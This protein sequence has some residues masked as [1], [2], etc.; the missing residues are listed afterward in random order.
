M[1]VTNVRSIRPKS[2]NLNFKELQAYANFMSEFRDACMFCISETWFCDMIDNDSVAID[3]FGVPFRTDRNF[4][5]S[6]KQ[7]GGGV[8][9]YI[10]QR[11]CNS[12]NVTVR[13]QL[14]TSDLD[15]L[16]VSLRPRYLPREFGQI[17]VT[18]VYTP[19]HANPARAA[20]QIADVVRDL[21]LISPDAPN[22]IAGDF[23]SCDLRTCLPTFHQY[24]S[25]PTRKT[26]TIDRL[27]GNIPDAY[28]SFVLPSVGK[29]DHDCAYL[30]PSYLPKIKS[31][32][33]VKKKKQ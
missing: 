9:L 19:P 30:I 26:K 27:Y 2:E 31:Q 29:S 11:W 8:C 4:A 13:K 1:I 28:K 21:Q 12:A 33:I 5:I 24:V 23:N 20:S 14:N 3:G 22:F 10:N 6:G 17:F 25:V 16:A 18:V 32:P 7:S 15:L